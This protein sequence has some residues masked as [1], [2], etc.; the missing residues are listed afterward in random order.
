M[1]ISNWRTNL[2]WPTSDSVD[3]KSPIEYLYENDSGE[4]ISSFDTERALAV[5]LLAEVVFLNSHWWES[6]WPEEA[7]KRTC[8][9]LD[10]SDVFIWGSADAISIDYAHIEEIYR[11][12]VKDP[13]WGPA[14]WGIIHRKLMPQAPVEKSINEHG[15]WNLTDL[16]EKY[17]LEDNLSG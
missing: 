3:V 1:I 17:G 5:L 2:E 6:D 4:T 9:C 12:W 15:I 16:K 13:K 11:Y 10:V 7:R 14:V 8:I